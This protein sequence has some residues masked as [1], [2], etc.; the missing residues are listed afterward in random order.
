MEYVHDMATNPHCCTVAVGVT[1]K[2]PKIYPPEDCTNAMVREL[3]REGVRQI[4]AYQEMVGGSGRRR[5]CQKRRK[6]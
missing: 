5:L 2:V 6:E 4:I 3:I 1:T